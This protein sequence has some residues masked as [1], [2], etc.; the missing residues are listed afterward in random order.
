MFR[1][2]RLFAIALAG[3]VTLAA[4]ALA[5]EPQDSRD[6]TETCLTVS[7]GGDYKYEFPCPQ[8]LRPLLEQLYPP[9]RRD[10]VIDPQWPHDQAMLTDPDWPHDWAMVAPRAGEEEE[11]IPLLDELLSLF[12][13][14]LSGHSEKQ[15]QPSGGAI[16]V[17][18]NP[19]PPPIHLKPEA[20]E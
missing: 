13:R 10:I 16:R 1:S 19:F 7:A 14:N 4:A 17:I 18:Q 12:E 8:G 20:P 2:S 15:Q 9:P 6:S 11:A 3:L 5:Q